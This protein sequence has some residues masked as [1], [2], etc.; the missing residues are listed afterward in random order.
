VFSLAI[1]QSFV[2]FLGDLVVLSWVGDLRFVGLKT[3]LQVLIASI[4]TFRLG[5]C[6][7]PLSAFVDRIIPTQFND[8]SMH[9]KNQ[10]RVN[11]FDSYPAW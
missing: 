6:R 2:I 8:G 7:I 3:F 4:L 10:K 9:I 5:C 11:E 1:T